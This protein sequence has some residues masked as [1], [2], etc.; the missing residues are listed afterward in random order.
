MAVDAVKQLGA[1]DKLN[2]ARGAG[3]FVTGTSLAS[4]GKR[5]YAREVVVLKISS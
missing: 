3:T 1:L 5:D 4:D 2:V